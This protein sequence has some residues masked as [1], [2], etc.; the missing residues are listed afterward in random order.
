MAAS[1]AAST[2]LASPTSLIRQHIA[3]LGVVSRAYR[4]VRITVVVVGTQ[5]QLGGGRGQA[6]RP[7]AGRPGSTWR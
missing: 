2:V 7:A 3:R 1:T 5:A 4:L 6:T